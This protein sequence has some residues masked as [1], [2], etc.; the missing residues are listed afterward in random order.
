MDYIIVAGPIKVFNAEETF[1]TVCRGEDLTL[2]QMYQ[3]EFCDVKQRV[4]IVTSRGNIIPAVRLWNGREHPLDSQ[5]HECYEIISRKEFNE[6]IKGYA[7]A[8][9]AQENLAAPKEN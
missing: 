8:K 5:E 2:R 1:T 7:L 3:N 6:R 9:S 4:F